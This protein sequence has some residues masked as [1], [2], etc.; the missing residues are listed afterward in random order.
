MRLSR[1]QPA[2]IISIGIIGGGLFALL[3]FWTFQVLALL[4]YGL[5][6]SAA[7]LAVSFPSRPARALF[8]V[9]VLVFA[10]LLVKE[11]PTAMPLRTRMSSMSFSN[12]SI[13]DVFSRISQQRI[14]SPYW[15]FFVS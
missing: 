5:L 10:F 9:P 13:A 14:T 11:I 7:L 4:T 12:A 3:N 8:S 15:R 6:S 2:E 1:P